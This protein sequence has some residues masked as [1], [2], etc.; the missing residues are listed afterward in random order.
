MRT[1][2]I[3]AH[4]T[5]IVPL[6][7]ALRDAGLTVHAS[8]PDLHILATYRGP[9]EDCDRL[10]CSTIIIRKLAVPARGQEWY[11]VTITLPDESQKEFQEY[12]YV[13]DNDL[14]HLIISYLV[15][16]YMRDDLVEVRPG[17]PESIMVLN[18]V[19]VYVRFTRIE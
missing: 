13:P 17:L 6:S 19:H 18:G 15:G 5:W 10:A 14:C 7:Q 2:V 4:P 8:G 3:N 12:R 1:A 16:F 11:E 9:G